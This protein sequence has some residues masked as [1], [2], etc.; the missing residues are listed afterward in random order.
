M[1]ARANS[2]AWSII[3]PPGNPTDRPVI[4]IHG[5]SVWVMYFEG[6]AALE[7]ISRDDGTLWVRGSM[8]CERDLGGSF[9]PVSPSVIWAYCGT[10]TAGQPFVSTNGGTTFANGG[11]AGGTFANGAMVAAVSARSAFVGAGLSGLAATTD[12][13]QTYRRLTQFTETTWVGFTDTE[14][15]YVISS[16]QS[17]AARR[18]WRTTD[19]EVDWS[20]VAIP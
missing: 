2:N 11:G 7:W 18:L 12:G 4:G 6:S 3:M 19:A 5:D 15:G 10:G 14:V 20:L 1:R 8:P 9:D 17:G 13:G 16:D